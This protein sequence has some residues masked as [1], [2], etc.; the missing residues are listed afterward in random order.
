MQVAAI[1]MAGVGL[2]VAVFAAITAWQA[3]QIADPERMDRLEA[4]ITR[5]APS[6]VLKRLETDLGELSRHASQLDEY[7][8]QTGERLDTAVQRVGLSRFNANKEI[9]GD[10]SFAWTVLDARN[11]GVI[12]TAVTDHHGTR[13]FVRG[14]VAGEPQHPLLPNEETSLQQALNC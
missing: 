1:V 5:Q 13:V 3:K 7:S 11:H 8:K 2:I 6:E 12:L 10:L 14:I 9:G 4:L